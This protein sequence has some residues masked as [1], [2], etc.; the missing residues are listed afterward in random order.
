MNQGQNTQDDNSTE[1]P[2]QSRFR[3]F[4]DAFNSTLSQSSDPNYQVSESSQQQW[5]TKQDSPSNDS[6]SR[7]NSNRYRVKARPIVPLVSNT[8][9]N[10]NSKTFKDSSTIE[11]TARN[12]ILNGNIYNSTNTPNGDPLINPNL[13]PMTRQRSLLNV[14]GYEGPKMPSNYYSPESFVNLLYR[15]TEMESETKNKA[16]EFGLVVLDIDN[17][18]GHIQSPLTKSVPVKN[19]KKKRKWNQQTQFIEKY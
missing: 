19:T 16:S 10:E 11:A 1:T 18:R 14:S 5:Q 13:P 4:T 12:N 15:I 17:L 7:T 2:W 9:R 6:V 8:P 3:R